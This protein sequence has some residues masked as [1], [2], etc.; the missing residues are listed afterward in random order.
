MQFHAPESLDA[1]ELTHHAHERIRGQTAPPTEKP[2]LEGF[3]RR[4][5]T[6]LATPPGTNRVKSFPEQDYGRQ[7]HLLRDDRRAHQPGEATNRAPADGDQRRPNRRVVR[8]LKRE[9][10]PLPYP[11]GRGDAMFDFTEITGEEADQIAAR[12]RAQADDRE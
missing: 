11:A 2:E 10:S 3:K 9:L 1:K 4:V 6:L 8:N 5:H 12:I 7:G